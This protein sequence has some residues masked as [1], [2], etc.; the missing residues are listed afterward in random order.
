METL[1]WDLHMIIIIISVSQVSDLHD[2]CLSFY[3]SQHSDVSV[4]S[5]CVSEGMKSSN[6]ETK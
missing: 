2:F 3:S 5:F 6:R 4:M 1:H